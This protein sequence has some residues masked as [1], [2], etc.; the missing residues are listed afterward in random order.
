MRRRKI[1]VGLGVLFCVSAAGA[2]TW[3]WLQGS[4]VTTEAEIPAGGSIQ[5]YMKPIG[6]TNPE[7][8]TSYAIPVYSTAG[9]RDDAEHIRVEPVNPEDY[10]YQT[11]EELEQ[12]VRRSLGIGDDTLITIRTEYHGG[13]RGLAISG[14]RTTR[15]SDHKAAA[16][17]NTRR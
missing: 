5:A 3:Y 11:V 8:V 14:L 13:K 12:A 4:A 1:L 2:V 16:E 9:S 6:S 17:G 7:N 15:P 10:G